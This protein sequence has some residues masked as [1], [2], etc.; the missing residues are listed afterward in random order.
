MTL[1][2]IRKRMME[3]EGKGGGS[4]YWTDLYEDVLRAIALGTCEE[5]REAAALVLGDNL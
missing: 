4:E 5:P 2:E 1:E 3:L